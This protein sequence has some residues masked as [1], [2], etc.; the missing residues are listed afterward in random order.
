MAG[1]VSVKISSD[2]KMILDMIHQKL[3]S[4]GIKI[5]EKKILDILLEHTD[6]STIKKLLKKEDNTALNMIKKPL[7][8]GCSD[9]SED[10]DKYLYGAQ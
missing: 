5:T 1:N 4:S 10:I 3:R 6:E 2:A 8:W 7:H 9:S